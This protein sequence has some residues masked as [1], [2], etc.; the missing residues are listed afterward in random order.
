M[1]IYIY[2]S[3]QQTHNSLNFS[4]N[5]GSRRA[6]NHRSPEPAK[7]AVRKATENDHRH[8][9]VAKIGIL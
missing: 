7:R 1:Y 2:I 4:Y 5:S 6:P 8:C 9:L 3:L